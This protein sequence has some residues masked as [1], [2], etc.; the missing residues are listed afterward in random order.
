[1]INITSPVVFFLHVK[2]K[3]HGTGW[4]GGWMDGSQSRVEDCLQ[5]SKI[6][7]P[8]YEL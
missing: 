7:N 3:K 5:Q 1:M 6:P 2:A 4:M 8:N